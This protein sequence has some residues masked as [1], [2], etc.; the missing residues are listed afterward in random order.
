M[1]QQYKAYKHLMSRHGFKPMS[2]KMWYGCQM[3]HSDG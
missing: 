2:F 1:R 3:L